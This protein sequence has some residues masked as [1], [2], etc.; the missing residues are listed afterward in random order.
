MDQFSYKAS[1]NMTVEFVMENLEKYTFPNI[2]KQIQSVD[3]K[4][5]ILVVSVR[6]GND[7]IGMS[8]ANYD[9]SQEFSEIVS[10]YIDP[11]YRNKGIGQELLSKTEQILAH[12][13]YKEVRT[14]YWSS[15][16]SF[17]ATNHMLKKQDWSEPEQLMKLFR[18]TS[19]RVVKIPFRE[20]VVLPEN[21]KII[22]WSW[23][24]PDEKKAIREEQ[25]F[26][27]FYPEYL[28]PFNN[29]EKINYYNSLALKYKDKLAGW[30]IAYWY[31][32]ETIEYSNLFIRPEYRLGMKTP[33]EMIKMASLLQVEQGIPEYLW[34]VGLEN[35]VLEE[36]F[37]RK[38]GDYCEKIKIYRSV[39]QL[40]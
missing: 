17:Q 19:D 34:L 36:Y 5:P 3:I 30:H 29:E 24:S 2:R 23:I 37:E 20:N 38:F 32:P 21:Y 12:K 27:P 7:M 39:K 1:F 16:D 25:E 9:M 15:W 6:D 28:S 31:S 22:P 18:T 10:F 26:I 14:Y 4:N 35:P 13:G 11:K 33:L 40:H 8:I